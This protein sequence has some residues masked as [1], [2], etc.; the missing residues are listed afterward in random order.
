MLR[1][2]QPSFDNPYPASDWS[3]ITD[4]EYVTPLWLYRHCS[5]MRRGGSKRD[6]DYVVA[7]PYRVA[8][9]LDGQPRQITV[10]E[11]ML[12]DLASV[13]RIARS[14]ISRVGPHLEASIVHDF[15][16]IAWQDIPGHKARKE[17]WR[18]ADRLMRAA[19][20]ACNVGPVNRW[21]IF[22]AVSNFGWGTYEKADPPPR[23]VDVPADR[24]LTCAQIDA[25]VP[26]EL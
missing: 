9:K 20:R 12:T 21:L 26:P 1:T 2:T 23:Y 5:A 6:A 25:A 19:M 24:Y 14:I 10:P 8:F 3:E 7:A 18:F 17:D 11:G 22:Q 13:P 16:Y 4:F 15:L